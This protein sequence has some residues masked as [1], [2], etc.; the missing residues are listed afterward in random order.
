MREGRDEREEREGVQQLGNLDKIETVGEPGER[1]RHFSES[2][3][4]AARRRRA[5]FSSELRQLRRSLTSAG[6]SHPPEP[7]PE[8]A[9]GA[10]TDDFGSQVRF[11][12]WA[13]QEVGAEAGGGIEEE[14]VW[15]GGKEE[16]CDSY[17]LPFDYV[18]HP[19]VVSSIIIH[20]SKNGNN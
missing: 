5:T 8:A 2:A 10:A 4:C 11:D 7:D 1:T 19:L 20:P 17:E 15:A 6:R 18:P 3:V 9:E 12:I 14:E 13:E 16:C